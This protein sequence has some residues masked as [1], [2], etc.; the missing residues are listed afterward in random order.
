M[1]RALFV[2]V[3]LFLTSPPIAS[4]SIS[5][6]LPN[7]DGWRPLWGL[8]RIDQRSKSLDDKYATDYSG[9]GVTVYL[10][11]S[12]VNENHREIRGRIAS[13]HSVVVGEPST[14]DCTGHGTGIAGVIAG[15]TFGVAKD[16]TIVPVRIFGCSNLTDSRTI[17][18]GIQWMITHHQPGDLAVANVSFG[19]DRGDEL[20]DQAVQEALAVGIHVVIA[21]G[22]GN[23][24]GDACSVSPGRVT[25]AILVGAVDSRLRKIPA[26]RTGPCIDIWAPGERIVTARHDSNVL[27]A[28]NTSTSIA[29]PFVVGA[30]ALLLEEF[31]RLSTAEVA[32][33]ITKNATFRQLR[34]IGSGSP[35][36]LL[37]V[38]TKDR[39]FAAPLPARCMPETRRK[40]GTKTFRCSAKNSWVQIR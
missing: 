35:N 38:G 1:I 9:K 36:R 40:V 24:S 2:S 3:A 11:D 29:A 20:L 39:R 16:A 37:Y 19:S 10:I 34:G 22:G 15:K 30:I 12:G 17:T 8:D 4:A 32:R 21:A 13:G 6:P 7:D 25:D 23:N 5:Q 26:S 28:V 31:G 27:T 14:T 18:A 33:L